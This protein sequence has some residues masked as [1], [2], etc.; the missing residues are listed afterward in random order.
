VLLLLAIWG[1]GGA[2]EKAFAAAA[3]GASEDVRV[4]PIQT[5]R[6]LV[7]VGQFFGGNDGW[8]GLRAIWNMRADEATVF[9]APVHVYLI[10]HPLATRLSSCRWGITRCAWRPMCCTRYAI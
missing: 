5:E 10:V 7:S 4:Y 1:L 9:W 2:P 3:M 6:T 8:V